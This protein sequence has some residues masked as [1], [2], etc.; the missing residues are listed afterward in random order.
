MPGNEVLPWASKD[1]IEWI[2]SMIAISAGERA[3]ASQ[4]N[5]I[6]PKI[7]DRQLSKVRNLFINNIIYVCIGVWNPVILYPL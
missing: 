7:D 4:V 5:S 1:L 6:A 2:F 3:S